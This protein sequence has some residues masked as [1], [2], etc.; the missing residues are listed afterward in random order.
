MF[1]AA[2][3]RQ[4]T[5]SC[6]DGGASPPRRNKVADQDEDKQLLSRTK[7]ARALTTTV[8]RA[9]FVRLRWHREEGAAKQP[10]MMGRAPE[11]KNMI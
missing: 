11:L 5:F 10:L 7:K 8:A 3:V 2:F 1:R 4:S 9:A 6:M